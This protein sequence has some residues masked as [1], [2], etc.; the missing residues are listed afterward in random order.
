MVQVN[1][2]NKQNGDYLTA[3]NVNELKSGINMNEGIL[4]NG[5]TS[6]YFDHESN[7]R[8]DT[9]IVPKYDE[10]YDLGS[11]ANKVRHLFLSNG[12]LWMGDDVKIDVSGDY[13]YTHIRNKTDLPSY[14]KDELNGDIDG[15][16]GFAGVDDISKVSLHQLE[17]YAK[18]L[19]D[20]ADISKIYPK[21]SDPKFK[22]TDY[23][24]SIPIDFKTKTFTQIQYQDNQEVHLTTDIRKNNKLAIDMKNIAISTINMHVSGLSSQLGKMYELDCIIY[25]NSQVEPAASWS[26][27]LFDQD[28]NS[29]DTISNTVPN[30]DNTNLFISNNHSSNSETREPYLTQLQLTPLITGDSGDLVWHAFL[31]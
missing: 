24:E 28:G 6:G 21:P 15:L 30:N 22:S 19:N 3:E 13:L 11:S 17:L 14:I 4:S 27:E 31:T 26:I 20:E 1:F 16:T 10:R 5:L 18:T 25:N 23:S 7:L 12:S 29:L 8:Y 2:N 9:H